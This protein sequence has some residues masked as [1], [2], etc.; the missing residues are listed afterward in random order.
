MGRLITASMTYVAVWACKWLTQ[1]FV[2]Q[3]ECIKV[4][5]AVG[6]IVRR[7]TGNCAGQSRHVEETSARKFTVASYSSKVIPL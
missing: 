7:Y 5:A 6:H 2:V 1:S 3:A 4:A